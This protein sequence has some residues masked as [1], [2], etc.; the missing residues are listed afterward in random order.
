MA[1]VRD[2]PMGLYQ[3]KPSPL[4]PILVKRE[5]KSFQV[6]A[7][8]RT[9]R[10]IHPLTPILVKREQKSLQVLAKAVKLM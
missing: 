7:K 10:N 4:T 2:Y 5:Q 9:R 8:A 6:L 1:F 3:K